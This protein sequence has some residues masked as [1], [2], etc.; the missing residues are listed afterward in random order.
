MKK[1]SLAHMLLHCKAKIFGHLDR[2]AAIAG[3]VGRNSR[4]YD[5]VIDKC[6]KVI[7]QCAVLNTKALKIEAGMFN[8]KERGRCVDDTFIY[9][10]LLDQKGSSV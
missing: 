4:L 2:V 7:A 8:V 3:S 1:G 9:E 10:N 6:L 5:G